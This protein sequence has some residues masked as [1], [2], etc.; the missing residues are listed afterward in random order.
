MGNIKLLDCTLRDGGY[1][2]KWN[3]GKKAIVDSINLLN[4]TGVDIVEV[5]FIR[6]VTYDED[7]SVFSS[8]EQVKKVIGKKKAGIQYAVMAEISNPIP[9]SMVEDADEDGPDIVRVICWKTKRTPEGKVVDALHE[10][11]EYC[12]GFIEKG[13]KVCVQPNRVDQYSDEDFLEMIKLFSTLNP[14]AIYIVDSWGTLYSDQVLHYMHLA[15]SVMPQ[16]ISMGYHGHNNMMQA[17]ANAEAVIKEK[18]DREIIIDGSI[19]GIGRG[20][21]NLNLELIAKYMNSFCRKEYHVEPMMKVYDRSLY[22]ISLSHSWGYTFPYYITASYNAN[23]DYADYYTAN[24]YTTIAQNEIINAI[25]Q[26]NRIIFNKSNA[27][28]FAAECEKKTAIIIPT[29]DRWG[30]IEQILL[31]YTESFGKNI[32]SIWILNYGKSEKTKVAVYNYLLSQE[33]DIHYKRISENDILTE[34]NICGKHAKYIWLCK[35]CLVP[36]FNR[37]VTDVFFKETGACYLLNTFFEDCDE[38]GI[39]EP[40]ADQFIKSENICK[41]IAIGGVI[42]DSSIYEDVANSYLEEKNNAFG[43]SISVIKAIKDNN[44]KIINVNNWMFISNDGIA[45]DCMTFKKNPESYLTWTKD[46]RDFCAKTAAQGIF[47]DD[48]LRNKLHCYPFNNMWN[49]FFMRY[50]N[51][52]TPEKMKNFAIGGNIS[53]KQ[54][55]YFI[56][57]VPRKVAQKLI[58]DRNSKEVQKAMNVYRKIKICEED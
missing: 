31:A 20:A 2:N 32:F 43:I 46:W 33:Y 4:Q 11:Y 49:V 17:F 54:M 16:N 13:Y 23:P 22:S 34:A 36:N 3:W 57:H 38:E 9:L 28:E 45:F 39:I 51:L 15:D 48:K 53:R 29:N 18:F 56:A 42:I 58:V 55:I 14:M 40:K 52:I 1:V 35:D 5:G 10:S 6:D 37:F 27:A 50:K 8:M 26:K 24:N 21:G 30:A 41:V 44:V 7:I 25:P 12:K 47:I 19:Y